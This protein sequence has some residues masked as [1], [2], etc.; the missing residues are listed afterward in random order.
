MN[1]AILMQI[2]TSGPWGKNMRHSTLA[3]R[4]S[5]VKVTWCEIGHKSPFHWDITGTIQRTLTKPGRHILQ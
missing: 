2:G 1:N 4:K 3:I 5:K